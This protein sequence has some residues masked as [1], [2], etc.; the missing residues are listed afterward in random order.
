MTDLENP[1]NKIV[2]LG[3]KSIRKSYY[4]EL[5]EKIASLDRQNLL[6]QSILNSIPDSIVITTPEG[7]I[8]QV[9]PALVERFGYLASELI[10]RPIGLLYAEKPDCL[11]DNPI[12]A[13]T[14]RCYQTKDGRVLIGETH[15]SDIRDQ[16][17]TQIGYLEVI[18]DIT[19]K[20]ET[21]SR[22]KK[23][24]EQLRQS[25]KMEAIG[26]IAGGIS[27]DF[28]NILSGIIGYAE[29]T[30]LLEIENRQAI[31]A[32]I[33][34][35][36]QA[37]Y[38]ARDLV[39]QI[40]TFSR[41]GETQFSPLRLSSVIMEAV[42]ILR[43]ALPKN[44]ELRTRFDTISDT[45]YADSTQMHQVVMNL[46]TNGAQ[47][48]QPAGGSIVLHLS[49]LASGPSVVLQTDDRSTGPM[50]LLEVS[51]TGAGMA[52][53]LLEHIFEPYFT[54]KK[55]GEGTGFGLALVH[56]IVRNH[57][58]H[59]EVESRPGQGT[60]FRIYLPAGGGCRG[61]PSE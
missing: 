2:G 6:Y 53:E 13:E 24:E 8:M 55:K 59:I 20:V 45:I 4:P 29:M 27:H 50:L 61:R 15:G 5:R 38:R 17:G 51:D 46:C 57:Q 56:R 3:N 35:I 1:I 60:R 16:N 40:L 26:T 9:N 14:A 18:R 39:K 28:N 48:M 21:L 44:V 22:Q 54:T 12:W 47:A 34:Q 30:E 41:R 36:L 19:E 37:S 7:S 58:G 32:N 33:Q 52:P 10:G 31:S 42:Q 49:E 43:A 11:E 25:R 23:L